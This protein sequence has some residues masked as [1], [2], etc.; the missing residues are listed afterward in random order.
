MD[1]EEGGDDA[2]ILSSK[3]VISVNGHVNMTAFC[4]KVMAGRQ[5][6]T[7]VMLYLPVKNGKPI[8]YIYI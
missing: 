1:R 2:I 4:H 3:E 6:H 8:C 5:R 7:Q